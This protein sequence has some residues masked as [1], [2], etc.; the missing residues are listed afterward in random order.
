[1][2]SLMAMP[3]V[4]HVD[5]M[6]SSIMVGLVSSTVEPIGCR[7]DSD[8]IPHQNEQST[9][10]R[11]E[12]KLAFC[13]LLLLLLLLLLLM[14]QFFFVF[15]VF[16]FVFDVFMDASC[17]YQGLPEAVCRVSPMGR[18]GLHFVIARLV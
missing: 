2:L 9:P 14:L 16:V 18:T 11:Y 17:T 10:Y 4:A 7:P 12:S 13:M 15:F 3:L 8:S 6:T 1:M 5:S